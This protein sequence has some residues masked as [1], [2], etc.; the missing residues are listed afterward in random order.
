M[1]ILMIYIFVDAGDIGRNYRDRRQYIVC[2]I[3]SLLNQVAV[4][5]EWRGHQGESQRAGGG[6]AAL[7]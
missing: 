4:Y 5:L 3:P 2:I 7:F 1:D 6:G